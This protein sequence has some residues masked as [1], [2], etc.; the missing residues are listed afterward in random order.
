MTDDY[1]TGHL[2]EALAHA[3]ETDVHVRMASGRVVLTGTVTT[4]QRRDEITAIAAAMGDAETGDIEVVNEVTVLR[5]REPDE[6]E[7]LH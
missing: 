1:L 6:Q 2:E 7:D 4:E 3:G 5:C